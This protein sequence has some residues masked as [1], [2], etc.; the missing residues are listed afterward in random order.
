MH[1]VKPDEGYVGKNDVAVVVVLLSF[2]VEA[3]GNLVNMVSY[4]YADGSSKTARTVTESEF[5]DQFTRAEK[6]DK[7]K[8]HSYKMRNR[9]TGKFKAGSGL[10]TKY[11][12]TWATIGHLRLHV[13]SKIPL[14]NYKINRLGKSQLV[15]YAYDIRA[16]VDA[17]ECLDGDEKILP[18]QW[19]PEE[20]WAIYSGHWAKWGF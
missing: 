7:E 2:M 13:H 6:F 19:L 10:D 18:E 3:Y 20:H 8:I 16:M 9:E 14:S 17:Y 4:V 11:G 12:K 1:S 15:A 5:L